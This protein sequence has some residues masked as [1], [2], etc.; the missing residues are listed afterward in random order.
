MAENETP[1]TTAE[2]QS[3]FD[4]A[5]A[6][7]H[8]ASDWLKGMDERLENLRAVYGDTLP[9][10]LDSFLEAVDE[11]LDTVTE[12]LDDVAAFIDKIEATRERVAETKPIRTAI[13]ELR[14]KIQANR[15]KRRNKGGGTN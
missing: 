13:A 11:G 14:A 6:A 7:I 10:E 9:A 2:M 1:T 8:K 12:T 3:L 5:S 4:K 15:A